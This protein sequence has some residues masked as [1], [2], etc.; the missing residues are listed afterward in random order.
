MIEAIWGGILFAA[1]VIGFFTIL[2]TFIIVLMIWL[3]NRK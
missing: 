2:G 1:C 3:G